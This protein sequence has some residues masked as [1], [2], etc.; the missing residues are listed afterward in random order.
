MIAAKLKQLSL[1]LGLVFG[2]Y[3]VSRLLFLLF[4]YTL[5]HQSDI[6]HVVTAFL[7]GARYDIA[8]ICRTNAIFIVLSML[9]FLWVEKRGY[10]TFLKWLLVISNLPFLILNVVDYEYHKFTGQRA[11][12]SLLDM[13]NDISNQIGQLSFH[14]WY[15][16]AISILVGLALWYLQP[17]RPIVTNSSDAFSRAKS[18]LILVL[19]LTVAV[20]GGRG[21]WQRRRLTTALAQVGDKDNLSQLALNSTYT[22]INSQ[23]KC[24]T[25]SSTKVHYFANDEELRKQFPKANFLPRRSERAAQVY[26]NVVIIIVESLSAEFTG[27]GISGRSFTPFLDSL[28]QRGVYFRNGFADGRRSIDAPPSILAGLP[29][30]K[31]E[32]FFCTQSKRLHGLGSILKEQGYNTSFFHGGKNGTMSFDTFSLRMG[33]DTYYGLNE[34]PKPQDSDGI[35]GIYDEPFMQHF[36]QQLAQRRQPFASALFT[37]STHNPYKVPDK[38]ADVLPTGDQPILQ[39]VAYFDLA[40][41]NFF[42]T[43]EKMDWY[44]NT[45]FI[46]TG[47]HIGPPKSIMPRMI[48]SYRVPIV[49]FHPSRQ[50]PP[51]RRD[52]IVQHVDIAPSILDY[53]GIVTSKQ[54]PFGHTIFDTAYEGLAL[55]QKGGN[56]WIADKNYYL[57]F[58]LGAPSQLFAQAQLDTPVSD[59]PEIQAQLEN[60]L[61]AYIQWFNNGLAED[62]LYR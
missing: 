40:L 1:R 55:G 59:K 46:V 47:D 23:R 51:V 28:A 54:L 29:H 9:P 10:Q 18:W 57:E 3:T 61:K 20:I 39:T 25:G 33:F 43:A 22:F 4:N 44:K 2:L 48:D 26:D 58:R 12:L 49:F 16:T 27:T 34:Y 60:K 52:R 37:L 50:L 13:G 30:L 15:L 53:L 19:V 24:D 21:G 5:F 8:A 17:A 11:S 45:L 32:T 14:Y 56:Y 42:A 62:K 38:Y 36:A 41:K 35:W 31:D 6:N 7:I